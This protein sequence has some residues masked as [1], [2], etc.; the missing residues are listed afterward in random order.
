M[1]LQNGIINWALTRHRRTRHKQQHA[2]INQFLHVHSCC[3][4]EFALLR[5]AWPA[6]CFSSNSVIRHGELMYHG[7]VAVHS[8]RY[9]YV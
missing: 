4:E 9:T 1:V 7:R 2:Y 3:L 8:G 6:G 5:H